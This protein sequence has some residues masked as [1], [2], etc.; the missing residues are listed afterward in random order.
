M[1]AARSTRLSARLPHFLRFTQALALVSSVGLPAAALLI[2]TPGCDAKPID[3]GVAACSSDCEPYD[4]GE[5]RD[6]SGH[7][8]GASGILPFDG[9]VVDAGISALPDS[10]VPDGLADVGPIT[11]A[12]SDADAESEVEAGGGPLAPPDLPT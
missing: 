8:D 7:P 3:E 6:A 10:E 9:G 2:A 1:D 12:S 5:P 4:S 11:D